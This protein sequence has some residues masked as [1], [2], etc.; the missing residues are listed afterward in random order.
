MELET[1]CYHHGDLDGIAAGRVVLDKYPNAKMISINYEGKYKEDDVVGKRVVVVDFSFPDML[2]LQSLCA[3]LI[4]CDHHK[5]VKDLQKK[6]WNEPSIAGIRSLDYAGCMLTYAFF[7]D[8]KLEDIAHKIQNLDIPYVIRAVS[9][10]DMWQHKPFDDVD[11]FCATAFVK[12]T[13]PSSTDFERLIS[14]NTQLSYEY[15][16]TGEVL[17]QAALNRIKKIA[18]RESP[19]ML[20][21]QNGRITL[22]IVNATTDISMLGSYINREVGCDIAVIFEV[23]GELSREGE[24]YRPESCRV[25]LRSQTCNVGVVAQA[26]GGGGHPGAAA[27]TSFET[28]THMKNTLQST[29]YRLGESLRIKR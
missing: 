22:L 9:T 11:A 3:E 1:I 10:Y 14:G 12:L 4:W 21:P 26:L 16:A 23:L 18:H 20:K 25:S 8:I 15:I 13:S 19:V 17:L 28:P 5:T 6:A 29:I 7:N 2:A 27:Y 24:P